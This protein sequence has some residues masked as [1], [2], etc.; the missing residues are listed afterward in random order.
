MGYRRAVF[1]ID[2]LVLQ[3]CSLPTGIAMG[4]L[5]RLFAF[6]RLALGVVSL[7]AVRPRAL[8]ALLL[9]RAK[10]TPLPRRLHTL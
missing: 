8:V 10:S 7:P 3:V 2:E 6:N 5:H 4:R 1:V 9:R